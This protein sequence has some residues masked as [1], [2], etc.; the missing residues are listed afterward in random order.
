MLQ[1]R[2][3]AAWAG[4]SR[5]TPRQH[6]VMLI[7][8]A[9]SLPAMTDQKNERQFTL[10]VSNIGVG[11]MAKNLECSPQGGTRGQRRRR[12]P[13]RR[14]VTGAAEEHLPTFIDLERN[15][16]MRCI[17]DHLRCA[18]EAYKAPKL[19]RNQDVA[20]GHDQ[21]GRGQKKAL[22]AASLLLTAHL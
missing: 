4:C 22:A 9:C 16:Q 15:E 11:I 2:T 8:K 1:L 7:S 12:A 14:L 18:G 6:S 5:C 10:T 20:C 13:L 17:G 19:L 21:E 3:L